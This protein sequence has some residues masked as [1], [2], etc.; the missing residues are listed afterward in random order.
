MG[1]AV[2]QEWRVPYHRLLRY[3][4][5]SQSFFFFWVGPPELAPMMLLVV[6]L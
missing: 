3:A 1:L 6:G 2:H 5:S 4:G